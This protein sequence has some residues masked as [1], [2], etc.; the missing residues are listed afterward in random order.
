MIL[1]QKIDAAKFWDIHDNDFLVTR[2][3]SG[4]F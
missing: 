1:C 4:I 3:A 2:N